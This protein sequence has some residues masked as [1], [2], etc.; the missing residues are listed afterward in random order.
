MIQEKPVR[1]I[2]GWPVL[3]L[4][5][6][7]LVTALAL[8]VYAVLVESPLPYVFGMLIIVAAVVMLFGFQAVPPNAARALLLFGEYQGSITESGFYWVNPFVSKRRISLSR[9]RSTNGVWP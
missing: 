1:P 4:W 9:I 5:L 2:S 7:L 6:G 3:I 8:F